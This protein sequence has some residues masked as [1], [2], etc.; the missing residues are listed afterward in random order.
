[1]PYSPTRFY[2]PISRVPAWK[3]CTVDALGFALRLSVEVT[4]V[5]WGL[6]AR[7]ELRGRAED[8]AA[9]IDARDASTVEMSA[10]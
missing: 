2:M 7:V 5:L 6:V 9:F 10:W 3:E 4:P 8:L 1:M